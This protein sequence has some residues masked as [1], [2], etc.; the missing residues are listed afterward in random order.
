MEFST[1]STGVSIN[2]GARGAINKSCGF[3]TAIFF[4]AWDF[5]LES[6]L[7]FSIGLA[8]FLLL[9]LQISDKL[10]VF[11][12]LG[13]LASHL[14]MQLEFIAP[15]IFAASA[16]VTCDIDVDFVAWIVDIFIEADFQ[17]AFGGAKKFYA[18]V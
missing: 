13:E 18:Y 4:F 6:L 2:N 16:V 9:C 17:D 7:I 3:I 15:D 5:E 1:W 11:A 8:A 14:A 12:C 10:I